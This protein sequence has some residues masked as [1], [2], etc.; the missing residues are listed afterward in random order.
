MTLEI[1]QLVKFTT[2]ARYKE[3]NKGELARITDILV[4][5]PENQSTLYMVAK[6]GKKAEFWVYE[7][8]IAPTWEQ[9]TLF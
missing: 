9:L 5:F 6:Q 3:W 2:S 1:G 4:T 8:D 7:A